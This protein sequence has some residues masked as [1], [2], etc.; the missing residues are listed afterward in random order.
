MNDIIQFSV[1]HIFPSK[2]IANVSK[3][4]LLFSIN[5]RVYKSRWWE[6][7]QGLKSWIPSNLGE[8]RYLQKCSQCSILYFKKGLSLNTILRHQSDNDLLNID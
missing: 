4:A 8:E 5:Y 7:L 1:V 6:I 2:N 3:P